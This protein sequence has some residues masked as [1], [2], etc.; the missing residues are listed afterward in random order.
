MSSDDDPPESESSPHITAVV[1]AAGLGKRLRSDVPKPAFPICGRAMASHVIHALG[2]A[3]ISKAVA[4]VPPGE[5]GDLVREALAHD[6]GNTDLR[7]AVQQEPRGTADAVLAARPHVETSHVLVVNGDLPL[8]TA[9]HVRPLL[10]AGEC[11]AALATARVNDPARMG[12]ILRGQ[13]GSLKGIVEWRDASSDERAIDE[14]NLGFY[15]F[16]GD[17]FWPEI[18]HIVENANGEAYATDVIPSAVARGS[19]VAIEVDLGG[20]RLN[21]ETPADAADAE[22]VIRKRVIGRLSECGVHIPDRRAVW[23][24]ARAII[25][26]GSVIEPG[27]HIRGRTTVATRSRIGPNAVVRDSTIGRDCILESCT[28]R[29]SILR[30]EVEVGP[31]STIRPGCTIESRAHIGTHA[32]LKES[33]IGEGVQIG[34]FSYLGDADVGQRANIGAGAI[35]CNFDGESKHQTVIGEDAFI[36][37]DTMLV[38]PVVVGA[39]ARTGAGAVVTKDV[40]DDGVAVGHPARLTPSRRSQRDS[41]PAS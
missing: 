22:D 32:E 28:V 30:D 20:V 14:V 2:D 8:L 24:D 21:V 26:P 7:F 11:D 12:R 34:H 33:R 17:F 10:K 36:G 37:S 13:D 25:E 4:V 9:S 23:I 5:R 19:A 41:E 6:A 15:L 31:Y 16:S 18:E 3:G 38:A 35:T 29:G 40:P 1:L 39:R 27:S